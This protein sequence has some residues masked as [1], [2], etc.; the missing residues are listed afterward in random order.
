MTTSRAS[1][2][3]NGRVVGTASICTAW[4]STL[5]ERRRELN[6][7]YA[8]VR[9]MARCRPPLALATSAAR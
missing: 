6:A 5:S 9:W 1:I 7:H 2:W 4:W 8:T 3:L